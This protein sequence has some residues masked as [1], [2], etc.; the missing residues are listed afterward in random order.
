VL[1]A[2]NKLLAG[3]N[4][5]A[6]VALSR[7]ARTESRYRQ[8]ADGLRQYL[9]QLLWDGR[10]LHRARNQQGPYGTA[11]LEDYAYV[12]AGLQA[13]A[14]LTGEQQDRVLAGKVLQQ[15]WQRFYGADGWRL[16]E[17]RLLA[18]G[19]SETIL[20]DGPLPSPSA[21]MIDTSLKVAGKTGDQALRQ[22]ALSAMAAGVETLQAEPFW[23]ASHLDVIARW[24]A[25]K[26]IKPD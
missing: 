3:W 7:A 19:G 6:L 5:L 2:D 4:G 21:V 22:R 15:G 25:D 11:G 13:Y 20:A 12:A 1:P 17:S 16:S 8:A 14:E 9:A 18:Y 24:Q 23:Y 26:E 10:Q